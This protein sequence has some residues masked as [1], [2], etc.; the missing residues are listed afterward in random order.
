MASRY[1]HLERAFG[2]EALAAIEGSKILV[3]GAGG[4]GCEIIKNLVLSGF[5]A[6][7]LIDL[8]TIDVSNLNRQFLFRSKHVGMSKAEVAKEMAMHF[9]PEA[10]IKAHHG[11]VKDSRFGVQ[12]V[13]GFDLVINCLDNLSARQHVNRLCLAAKKPLIEAGT[14]GYAG[15]TN[16]HLAGETACLDC[17]PIKEDNQRT[18]AICTIRST[19]EKPV[20]CIVWAKE[21]FKLMFGVEKE[22]MLSGSEDDLAV[23]MEDSPSEEKG[24]NDQV[25]NMEIRSRIV[26]VVKERPTGVD[27]DNMGKLRAY[28]RNVFNAV[29][30]EEIRFKLQLKNGYKGAK[31]RPEPITFEAAVADDEAPNADASHLKDQ[32]V[33][34]LKECSNMFIDCICSIFS[35]ERRPSLGSMV[36]DKDDDLAMKFVTAA[37]NLRSQCF[38]IERK[39]LFDT[40]GIAGSIVHAIATTNAIV[41]GIQTLEAVKVLARM[42]G[43]TVNHPFI[44]ARDEKANASL[45]FKPKR[46]LSRDSTAV[47]VSPIPT[48]AGFLLQPTPLRDPKDSCVVCGNA[49]VALQV[50]TRTFTLAELVD[51]VL[52]GH[53]GVNTP[54]IMLSASEIYAE[55][56]GLDE[57]ELVSFAANLPKTL[58]DCPAGGIKDGTM[59]DVEDFSQNL[60]FQIIV[61]QA[62]VDKEDNPHLFAVSG[63]QP[64]TKEE[65]STSSSSSSAITNGHAHEQDDDV[66][67]VVKNSSR[68]VKKR[69][70]SDNEPDLS[71]HSASSKRSKMS[72]EVITLD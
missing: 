42:K 49:S 41:A 50:D 31:K 51:K 66:V 2:A 17:E 30:D 57:D 38:K 72:S 28:A 45:D 67:I 3:V 7:E 19:P 62:E 22:S 59:V 6:I 33:M 34:S 20:H 26:E 4:I 70:R 15:Q 46:N 24:G 1:A 43:A 9:N 37:S 61:Q 21:L 60:K 5:K 39:S 68:D 71:D 32:R 52:K 40:K 27:L 44:R 54:S 13:S 65:K 55:G 10:S 56:E 63:D 25:R 35:P 64:V 11:N 18:F 53:F 29:F 23:N 12:Y 36:F 58:V 69:N 47:W 16:L 14:A 8:D 48:A